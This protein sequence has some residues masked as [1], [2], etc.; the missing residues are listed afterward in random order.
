MKAELRQKWIDALRSGKYTQCT[1]KLVR[2]P[3]EERLSYCCLGVLCDVAG[4]KRVGDTFE[5]DM[6]TTLH[7]DLTDKA[8]EHF[9]M[10]RSQS[11][12]LVSLNDDEGQSFEDIADYIEKEIPCE[13]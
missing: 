13:A 5:M 1:G 4:F 12:C 3:S 10:K 9:N 7:F 8:L 6:V 11:A 2:N